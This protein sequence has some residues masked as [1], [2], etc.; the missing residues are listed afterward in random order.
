MADYEYEHQLC[1]IDSSTIISNY[2]IT[3]YIIA[4]YKISA[5]SNT[6]VAL[7]H[8]LRFYIIIIIIKFDFRQDVVH[9]Y[10]YT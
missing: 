1:F 9:I 3:Y 10:I 8:Q 5:M 7:I 6:K 4:K 2:L